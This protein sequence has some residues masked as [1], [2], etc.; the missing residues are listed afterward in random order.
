MNTLEL[1]EKLNHFLVV[2]Q[3]NISEF[4][5]LIGTIFLF[6]STGGIHGIFMDFLKLKKTISKILYYFILLILGAIL[7]LKFI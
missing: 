7:Y 3:I 4:K 5:Y 6:I 2:N 1:R